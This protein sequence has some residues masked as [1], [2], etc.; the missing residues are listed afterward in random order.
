[1][2]LFEA[3]MGV[4]AVLV[5]VPATV[6]FVQVLMASPAYRPSPAPRG[7]RPTVCILVPAHNEADGI[8]SALRLIV[9][10]LLTG[11]RLLVVADNCADETARVANALGAEV[12]ERSDVERRGKGYALDFGIRHLQHNP[13]EV[14]IVID[15]D[16]SVDVGAIDRLARRCVETGRP[17]QALDLMTAPAAAGLKTRIAEF[18]WVVKNQVRPLGFQRLGL[19]CQLMGTGMAFPWALLN[20]VQLGNDNIVEDMKLGI[21]LAVKGF[22]T[23]FCHEA[24]VTSS[25]PDGKKAAA[26]QRTRWEHGHL[27]TIQHELPA[28]LWKAARKRD[29]RL[30]GLALDLAV[31]PLSL[32]VMLL[33]AV[34]ICTLAGVVTG[35]AV[36]PLLAAS[37]ALALLIT[38]VLVAWQR[39]GR[40][41]V[42][43]ADLLTIPFYV[44]SKI[45]LYLKFWTRRQKAWVRTNR[46]G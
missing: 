30:L 9:P 42:S 24:M 29:M 32:L 35:L 40:R 28:L 37:I 13:P 15:A 25:F 19:P 11:D 16:C 46:N 45:P 27:H 1:M 12:I 5:L 7:R 38:A 34:F 23:L 39:W 18:A 8:A 22:P 31:P 41:L 4:A 2:N 21:D 36:W 26:I 3:L 17:I 14:V 20:E 44:I 33:L 6:F 43:M 10:Q